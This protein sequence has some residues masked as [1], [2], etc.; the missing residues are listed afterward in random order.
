MRVQAFAIAGPTDGVLPRMPLAEFG[1]GRL[2]RLERRRGGPE[3]TAM[4]SPRLTDERVIV[5]SRVGRRPELLAVVLLASL[6]FDQSLSQSFFQ[7][8]QGASEP[9]ALFS[10][11]GTV[12]VNGSRRACT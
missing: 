12:V 11:G 5:F 10:S 6:H 2:A 1:C 8:D 3:I 4:S 9:T 7:E